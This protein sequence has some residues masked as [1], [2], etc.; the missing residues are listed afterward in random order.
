MNEIKI[1]KE[2]R[3]KL[4]IKKVKMKEGRSRKLR[5]KREWEDR[6]EGKRK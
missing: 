6:K 1:K 5:V 4:K 3:T 2:G